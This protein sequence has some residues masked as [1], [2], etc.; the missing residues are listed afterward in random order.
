MADDRYIIISVAYEPGTRHVQSLRRI[1]PELKDADLTLI[2][3]HTRPC[4][5][6][7]WAG[8]VDGTTF[9]H[10]ADAWHLHDQPTRNGHTDTQSYTLDGMNWETDG[11]SPVVYLT[12]TVS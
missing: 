11:T 6:R 3:E 8:I 12:L 2:D 5:S 1:A 4:P 9:A 7:T 10:L